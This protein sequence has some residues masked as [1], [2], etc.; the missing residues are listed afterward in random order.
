[1]KLK[2]LSLFLEN[3]PGALSRPIRVLANAHCNILTLSIADASQFGILRLIVRDWERAQ[4][5]FEQAGFV[6]KVT[7]VMAVE[8]PDRPGGLAD[9]L[10]ILDKGGINVEFMYAFTEK[11]LNR[12]VLIFRFDDPDKAIGLLQKTGFDPGETV[13]WLTQKGRP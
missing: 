11:R 13:D 9:I 4:Q 8:V 1:M 2:Q 7:E 5:V 10:D 3:K 6:V 12:G